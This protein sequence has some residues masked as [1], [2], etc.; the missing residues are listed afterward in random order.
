MLAPLGV[1]QSIK[2]TD[3]NWAGGK[4]GSDYGDSHITITAPQ[5]DWAAGHVVV[6][7]LDL[8]SSG[9]DVF[10]Y[11]GPESSPTFICA[12]EYR[13]GGYLT[14]PPG[15]T[16]GVDAIELSHRDNWVYNGPR[17]GERTLTRIPSHMRRRVCSLTA[18]CGTCACTQVPS[19]AFVR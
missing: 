4:F 14:V 5:G 7:S 9:E 18:A 6:V 3:R 2:V 13:N 10:V 15:L 19:G 1:G 16:K 8:T 11:Q 17:T 12:L